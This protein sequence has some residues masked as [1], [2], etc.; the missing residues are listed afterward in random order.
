MHRKTVSG[1]ANKTRP[2][3]VSDISPHHFNG[4]QGHES[5][6]GRW[7]SRMTLNPALWILQRLQFEF[8]VITEELVAGRSLQRA[9]LLPSALLSMAGL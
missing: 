3:T 7:D 5:L 1:A 8:L 6:E 4:V 9:V 2:Q